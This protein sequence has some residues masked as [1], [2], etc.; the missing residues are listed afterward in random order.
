MDVRK[1]IEFVKAKGNLLERYRIVFLFD[2]FRKDEIPLIYMR[3]I[4]NEDSGF[5]HELQKGRESSVCETVTM[6]EIMKELDL[7]ETDVARNA[8]DFLF[9]IQ[10]DDGSWDE[11]EAILRYGLP[12]WDMPGALARNYG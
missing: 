7:V 12:F 4:Q 10:G 5:P 8:I 11:N 2:R 1:A 6:L 9:N 3:N